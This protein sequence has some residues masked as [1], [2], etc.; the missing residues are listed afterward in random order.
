MLKKFAIL[1]LLGLAACTLIDPFFEPL[2]PLPAT[3]EPGPSLPPEQMTN[4]PENSS[5]T[6]GQAT[7]VPA[8]ATLT[9]TLPPAPIFTPSIPA[10]TASNTAT[11]STPV[12]VIYRSQPGTPVLMANYAHPEQGCQW[13]SV[14]GQVFD[15]AGKPV[16]NLVVQVRGTLNGQPFDQINLTGLALEYG[17]GGF[18]VKL[19]SQAVT[20]TGTLSIQLLDLQAHPLSNPLPFNTSADCTRNVTLINFLP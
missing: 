14:A 20:S 5:P 16:L 18:E 11:V 12:T 15:A 19:A 1:L 7:V 13:S 4:T 6:P 10:A 9:A 8:T 3:I 2:P 17:P